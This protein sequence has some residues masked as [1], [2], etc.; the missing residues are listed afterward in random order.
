M[1]STAMTVT[2]MCKCTWFISTKGQILNGWTAMCKWKVKRDI[3]H[4]VKSK[5]FPSANGLA[6]ST[7]HHQCGYWWQWRRQCHSK[8]QQEGHCNCIKATNMQILIRSRHSP[9]TGFSPCTFRLLKAT[10]AVSGHWTSNLGII[11]RGP[12]SSISHRCYC[13]SQWPK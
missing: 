1:S 4:S 6:T 12:E 3:H 5:Q 8:G 11:K 9:W 13:R 10:L 7:Q 2:A